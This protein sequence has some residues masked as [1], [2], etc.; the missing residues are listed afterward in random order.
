MGIGRAVY[1]NPV[2]ASDKDQVIRFL[3]VPSD[4][5]ISIYTAAGELVRRFLYPNP[6]YWDLRNDKNEKVAAGIYFFYVR[7]GDRSGSGKFAVIR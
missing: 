7:A 6:N 3:R 5:E 1:P 2:F 4:A